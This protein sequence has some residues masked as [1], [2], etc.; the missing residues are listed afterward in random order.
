M[1]HA[2]HFIILFCMLHASHYYSQCAIKGQLTDTLN[3]PIVF[4]AIGLL[5]ASDSSIVKGVMTD[6]HGDFCFEQIKK[7]AYQLKVSAIGYNTY[8]S[9]V[10]NYDSLSPIFLDKILLKAGSINLNEVS[11]AAQKKTI[12]YKMPEEFKTA[13]DEMK[14]LKTAFYKLTPG[15]QRGYLLYF[16]S[17][18]QAKTRNERVEKYIPKILDGKGLDD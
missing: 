1:K 9:N 17:A 11:V 15:R 16:S 6:D 7:G 18:K 3:A 4:N 10:F 13:L 14:D 5:N 8:Y 2:K 12:E